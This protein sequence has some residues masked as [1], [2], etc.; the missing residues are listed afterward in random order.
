[1]LLY[2][3][4]IFAILFYSI[5]LFYL[6]N[7]TFNF[8]LCKNFT[9]LDLAV[10]SFRFLVE[11]PCNCGCNF[12]KENGKIRSRITNKKKVDCV[13]TI[14]TEPHSYVQLRIS[15][16]RRGSLFV[17]I[18]PTKKAINLHA[19]DDNLKLP[20]TIKSDT[21]WMNISLYYDDQIHKEGEI[22]FEADFI[23]KFKLCL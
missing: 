15:A 22:Y 4:S 14:T 20:F 18:S 12:N 6:F 3:Y 16:I 7:L 5:Y 13:W 8:F 23:G 9:N 2:C 1:M 10:P 21:N 17:S 19:N 11:E